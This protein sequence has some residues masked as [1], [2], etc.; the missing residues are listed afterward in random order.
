MRRHETGPPPPTPT[1]KLAHL[2]ERVDEGGRLLHQ[3]AQLSTHQGQQLV[4]LA[5]E[6]LQ[7][8]RHL[9]G[10]QSQARWRSVKVPMLSM[11]AAHPC[12]QRCSRL[13]IEGSSAPCVR[14]MEQELQVLV[15]GGEAPPVVMPTVWR[16][17]LLRQQSPARIHAVHSSQQPAMRRNTMQ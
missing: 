17:P 3:A 13:R 16:C 2:Q 10:R 11:R 1:C 12:E 7:A 15:P 5:V 6:H 8:H 9:G 14:R 4:G